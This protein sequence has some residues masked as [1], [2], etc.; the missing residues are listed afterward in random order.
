MKLVDFRFV[1]RTVL[2]GL[3]LPNAQTRSETRRVLQVR[4]RIVEE[5]ALDAGR[6]N[7]RYAWPLV[8]GARDEWTEWEDVPT[9]KGGK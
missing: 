8:V 3:S 1:E 9:V 2:V 6:L 4:H 7:G 5:G